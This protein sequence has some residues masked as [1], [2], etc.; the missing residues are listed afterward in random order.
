MKKIIS[1]ALVVAMTVIALAACEKDT[2]DGEKNDGG[3]KS[4]ISDNIGDNNNGNNENDN[5]STASTVTKERWEKVLSN[6]AFT[7][8]TTSVSTITS[9]RDGETDI[10]QSDPTLI[11]EQQSE[12]ATYHSNEYSEYYQVNKDGV[13]YRIDVNGEGVDETDVELLTLAGRLFNQQDINYDDAIYDEDKKTY[14]VEYNINDNEFKMLLYFE[15]E[16]LVK[17]DGICTKEISASGNTTIYEVKVTMTVKNIG[18]TMI[19]VPEF[20]VPEN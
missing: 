9:I 19:D 15:N 10:Q 16:D 8:E 11:I 18:S 6:V 14:C 4:I 20:T 13:W 2:S 5:N 17:V 12:L 3:D 7:L 1:L